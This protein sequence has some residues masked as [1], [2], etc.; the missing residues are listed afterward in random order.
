MV[1]NLDSRRCKAEQLWNV[2]AEA[3]K[4]TLVWHRPGSSWP[5]TSASSDLHVVDGAQPNAINM[6]AANID[7]EKMIAAT[8]DIQE[9]QYKPRATNNTG[10][11]CII[12]DLDVGLDEEEDENVLLADIAAGEGKSVTN[13]ILKHSDGELA[14]EE[15]SL[16]MVTSPLKP[17]TGWANAPTGAK[18]F[19]IITSNGVVR[20]LALLVQS[21]QTIYDKVWIYKSK[22]N[23]N[24]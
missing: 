6:G 15:F 21:R 18:E 17:A 20:R 11:G 22:K 3:G 10:A 16:D 7:W 8:E 2:T 4:K 5:P 13:L 14:T 23:L 24:H 12:T 9:V 1:Y 19:S